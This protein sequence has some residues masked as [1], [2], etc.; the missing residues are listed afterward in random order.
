M[1]LKGEAQRDNT[2]FFGDRSNF[3]LKNFLNCKLPSQLKAVPRLFKHVS[4]E[5]RIS[6]QMG[7]T[8]V[9]EREQNKTNEQKIRWAD[10][11]AKV[12]ALS[13]PIFPTKYWQAQGQLSEQSHKQTNILWLGCVKDNFHISLVEVVRS[14]A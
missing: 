2:L 11:V 7:Q 8:A 5:Q 1:S 3:S 14:F 12:N 6:S 9:Y 13:P 4:G 10:I